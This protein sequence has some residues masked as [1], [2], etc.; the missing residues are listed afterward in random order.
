MFFKVY[1]SSFLRKLN[2]Y[3][4]EKSCP[5]LHFE[6]QFTSFFK[7]KNKSRKYSFNKKLSLYAESKEPNN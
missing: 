1:L 2:F 4:P 5:G 7:K 3:L 6:F